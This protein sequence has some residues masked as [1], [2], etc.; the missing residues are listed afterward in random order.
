[1]RRNEIFE[2]I[3]DMNPD[4]VI[5]E[6]DETFFSETIEP[7]DVESIKE[8]MKNFIND[9]KP[10]EQNTKQS[11][12]DKMSNMPEMLVATAYLYAKNYIYYGENVTKEWFTAVQQS[13]T[14]EK[15]YNRGRNDALKEVYKSK[16]DNSFAGKLKIIDE[17]YRALGSIPKEVLI[18]NH[19]EEVYQHYMKICF[20]KVPKHE[21]L[22]KHMNIHVEE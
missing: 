12:L 16:E 9:N 15:A 10:M 17:V 14:L 6:C 8:R 1:M 4:F 20:D 7:N 13:A 22:T 18:E 11:I 5:S 21:F 3:F 2:I 19:L